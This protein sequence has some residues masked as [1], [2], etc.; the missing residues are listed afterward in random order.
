MKITVAR[1]IFG[2]RRGYSTLAASGDVTAEEIAQLTHFPF[3]QT[4]S[5]SYLESLDENPA[6]FC[7]PLSTGRW[8]ITRVLKGQADEY[9]RATLLFISA[10]V[11]G[12]DWLSVLQCDVGPLLGCRALWQWE[13]RED[14]GEIE[15]DF[16]PQ[17]EK[18]SAEI[19][20]KVLSLLSALE[21]NE[22]EKRTTV[23]VGE[24][25]SNQEVF[26]WLNMVLPQN[27]KRTFQYAV[28]A[29][30]DGL[31]FPIMSVAAE[32]TLGKSGR[33]I[34][35]WETTGLAQGAFY[36]EYLARV[37]RAGGPAPWDFVR[38]CRNFSVTVA[39]AREI[40]AGA[41][42]ARAKIPSVAS[43]VNWK[44][45]AVPFLCLAIL[46]VVIV[47]VVP[48]WKLAKERERRVKEAEVF[49]QQNNDGQRLA[50]EGRV[51]IIQME[52]LL[53][54]VQSLQNGGGKE[55]PRVVNVIARL[56]ELL[57]GTKSE[58][59]RV[60]E[61]GN[62]SQTYRSL[63]LSALLVEYPEP[64]KVQR[65]ANFSERLSGFKKSGRM[66]DEEQAM[67]RM[68]LEVQ[69]WF[70]RIS[71]ILGSLGGEINGVWAQVD[72][73]KRPDSYSEKFENEIKGLD[74]KL[75][76][77]MDDSS[78]RNALK[79]PVQ[80]DAGA[81]QVLKDE[82]DVA[83]KKCA[84][85][86]GD[87][88]NYKAEAKRALTKTEEPNSISTTKNE[89]QIPSPSTEED[90]W[91]QAKKTIGQLEKLDDPNAEYREYVASVKLLAQG[92]P[93]NPRFGELNS[94]LGSWKK[95]HDVCVTLGEYV[96]WCNSSL[97]KVSQGIDE[98]AGASLQSELTTRSRSLPISTSVGKKY[99]QMYE[100][101]IN[102]RNN[103]HEK[104]RPRQQ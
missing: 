55:D 8:A 41:P 7:R 33:R 39:Q 63:G 103:L 101:A 42:K 80:K 83:R 16:V 62:L 49:L 32:G 58:I 102:K 56:R 85:F 94:R 24:S 76:S 38:S 30:G 22:K 9:H 29:L 67:R 81:A 20:D 66:P 57:E 3:G 75:K 51:G 84:G 68:G 95:A 100:E 14:A 47:F 93:N 12:E 87:M 48:K 4:N 79:S 70:E 53:S 11:A 36:S 104:L 61:F 43:S 35:R 59:G 92:D 64:N 40:A 10:V 6:Y 19:R 46:G 71:L 26:R 99:A 25:D 65:V 34:V 2:S 60:E 78:L 86:L 90:V 15:V 44:W 23:V 74:G 91:S 89:S 54:G 69:N 50:Q 77:F 37:W 1:H 31:G 5:A 18:P 45:V 13:G 52:S 73:Q 88:K 17:K 98:K 27:E 21:S 82:I 72:A 96:D 28:R 97:E